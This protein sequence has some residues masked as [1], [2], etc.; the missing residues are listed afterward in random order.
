MCRSITP[1]SEVFGNPWSS[2]SIVRFLVNEQLME[3][4]PQSRSR[5]DVGWAQRHS[6]HTIRLGHCVRRFVPLS[7]SVKKHELGS[8]I[9]RKGGLQVR[10]GVTVGMHLV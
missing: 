2:N 9:D 7:G 8:W 1:M 10:N 5:I 6:A 3:Y 4:R